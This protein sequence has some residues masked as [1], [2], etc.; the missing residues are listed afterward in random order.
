MPPI[1]FIHP[2]NP[3]GTNK[4]KTAMLFDD[5]LGSSRFFLDIFHVP[6]VFSKLRAKFRVGIINCSC[7]S[8]SPVSFRRTFGLMLTKIFGHSS[9]S[10]S[11]LERRIRPETSDSKQIGYVIPNQ[12]AKKLMRIFFRQQGKKKTERRT[13]E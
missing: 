7:V 9:M 3:D 5:V 8:F 11:D 12:V 10:P 2:A 13:S 6:Y 1:R 4:F